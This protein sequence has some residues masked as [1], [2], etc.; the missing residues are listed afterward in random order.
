MRTCFVVAIFC[1][2]FGVAPSFELPSTYAHLFQFSFSLKL[3][4]PLSNKNSVPGGS[5]QG[6]S[7]L[8][9]GMRHEGPTTRL[10][11]ERRQVPMRADGP[12]AEYNKRKRI[13]KAEKDMSSWPARDD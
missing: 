13:E 7:S 5:R 1:F 3:T 12:A 4:L 6:S 9:R 2:A 11:K 10:L 8:R